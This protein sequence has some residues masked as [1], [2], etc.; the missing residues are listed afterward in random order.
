[1]A[2]YDK[3]LHVVSAHAAELGITIGQQTVDE[4]SNEIPAVRELIAL[5][6]IDFRGKIGDSDFR[7]TL[8]WL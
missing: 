1:M 2:K 3:P 7:Q 8:T 4:K 6:N 5:L